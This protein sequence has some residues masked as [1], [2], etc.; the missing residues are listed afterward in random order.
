RKKEKQRKPARA[1]TRPSYRLL[2]HLAGTRI[3]FRVAVNRFA[4]A[5][6]L[7]YGQTVGLDGFG[8]LAIGFL[9]HLLLLALV[10]YTLELLAILLRQ[11]GNLLCG[12]D[13]F[14]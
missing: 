5:V 11:H 12:G 7:L 10:L 2:Q 14:A 9:D 8:H 3:Q 6:E 13:E 1:C 4:D